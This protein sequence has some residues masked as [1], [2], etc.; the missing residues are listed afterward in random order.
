MAIGIKTTTLIDITGATA[1]TTAD[2]EDPANFHCHRFFFDIGTAAS[3]EIHGSH[4][5]ATFYDVTTAA[6]TADGEIREVERPWSH[7]RVSVTGN[8]G[9]TKVIMQQFYS[10]TTGA[11]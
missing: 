4:D 3:I 1:T 10:N 11:L 7:L 6:I 8:T 9:V 2:V 5:G